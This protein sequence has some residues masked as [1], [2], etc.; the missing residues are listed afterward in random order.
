M[1]QEGGIADDD[2]SNALCRS[3]RGVWVLLDERMS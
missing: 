3:G 2:V 1:E